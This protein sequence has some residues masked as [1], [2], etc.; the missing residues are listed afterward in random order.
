M[1]PRVTIIIPCFNAESW[2]EQSVSSALA[3]TYDNVEV[4]V[5]DNES[6]DG[7]LAVIKKLASQNESL[8]TATAPNLYRHSWEE[9]VQE[10]LQQSTGDYITILGADDYIAPDYVSNFMKYFLA[11][12]DTVLCLQSP[13]RGVEGHTGNMMQDVGHSYKSMA[14][15][16]N[17]LF[18]KCPVNTPTVVFSRKLYDQGLLTWNAADYLGAADYDLYFNLADSDVFIYPIPKWLGYYYRWHQGQATW[19]MH[20]EQKSYDHIIRE[21]WA[22][23]WSP[24]AKDDT[25]NETS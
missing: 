23:K 13:I 11:K 3:Q 12:P 16:K 5:V 20:R 17:S 8:V 19:G 15:F 21:Y 18:E 22:R 10:A 9:P 14:E 2:I 1:K 24:T 4:I 25:L 6:T 7:S